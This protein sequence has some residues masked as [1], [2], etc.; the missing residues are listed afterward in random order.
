MLLLIFFLMI[1][2]YQ[3]PDKSHMIDISQYADTPILEA[4]MWK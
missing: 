2:H 1:A 4:H 3:R